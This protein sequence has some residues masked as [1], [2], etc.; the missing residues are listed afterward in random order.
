M[1]QNITTFTQETWNRFKCDVSGRYISVFL[2]GSSHLVLGEVKIN[3]TIKESPFV[4]ITKNKTWE[5]ALYYCRD[6]YLDLASIV[7]EETQAWAESEAKK[8]D[9]PSVW[10]GLHYTCTL[11]FWSW[12]D[13]QQVKF[14]LWTPGKITEDCD[15]SGAMETQDGRLWFSKSD[16]FNFICAK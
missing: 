12:V 13:D 5:D 9:T 10:L 7:D 3:G 16:K 8:A 2:P 1:C 4:M 14:S 15:M 6:K 11:E